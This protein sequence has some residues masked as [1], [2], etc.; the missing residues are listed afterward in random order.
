MTNRRRVIIITFSVILGTILSAGLIF[1]KRG[2]MGTDE[3]FLLF[4]N[5]FFS[6]IIIFSIGYFLVW[7]KRDWVVGLLGCWV[8]GLMGWWVFHSDIWH[9]DI[10]WLP[11]PAGMVFSAIPGIYTLNLI[12]N[13]TKLYNTNNW[14][15]GNCI[16]I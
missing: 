11:C 3:Y 4:T 1:L 13:Y 8:D 10:N 5:L 14:L 7:R 2:K 12:P 6:V 15:Y 9:L 16:V